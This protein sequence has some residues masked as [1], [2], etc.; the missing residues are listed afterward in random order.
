M[1][2]LPA[3]IV[4]L[5]KGFTKHQEAL[6]DDLKGCIKDILSLQALYESKDPET[7]N[8]TLLDR[9]QASIESRLVFLQDSTAQAGVI[10]ECCR[11]AA[12]I[13]CYSVYTEVWSNSFIPMKLAERLLMHLKKTL[14]QAVWHERRDI[15]LW[16]VFVCTSTIHAAE[17]HYY[18]VRGEH[19]VFM[20]QLAASIEEWDNKHYSVRSVLGEYIYVGDWLQRR[21]SNKLWL[22]IEVGLHVA[23]HG[24]SQYWG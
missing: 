22:A 14:T 5:P 17:T 3:H 12:Y 21:L 24:S 1:E 7:C 10:S 6:T 11:L 4:D 23:T 16:L 2:A 15:F 18:A 8:F 20:R 13:C 9:W 19:E